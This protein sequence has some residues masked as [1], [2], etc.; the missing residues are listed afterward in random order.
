ARRN[1]RLAA[2]RRIADLSAAAARRLRDGGARPRA[3]GHGR[4]VPVPGV[5]SGRTAQVPAPPG[6]VMRSPPESSSGG[7]P[8]ESIPAPSF[9][10]RFR[11]LGAAAAQAVQDPGTAQRHAQ[12][13]SGEPR[14]DVSQSPSTG[15]A[16]GHSPSGSRPSPGYFAVR[17][18]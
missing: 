8:R 13:P 10:Y 7:S 6:P 1:R 11:R 2:V 12:Q 9:S 4:P 14:D 16:P 3:A 18:G 15:R 17:R 5:G